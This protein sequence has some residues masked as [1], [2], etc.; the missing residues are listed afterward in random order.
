MEKRSNINFLMSPGIIQKFGLD[1]GNLEITRLNAC[2]VTVR[3]RNALLIDT[4]H[5]SCGVGL[6]RSQIKI[7]MSPIARLCT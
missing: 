7:S 4:L 5:A 6:I 1:T 2:E 3:L